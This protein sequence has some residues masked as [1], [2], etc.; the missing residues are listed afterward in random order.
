MFIF[1]NNHTKK[2]QNR[3]IERR[4]GVTEILVVEET[5]LSCKGNGFIQL[6][7]SME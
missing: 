1:L 3:R 4:K 5:S 6:E 7:G 2:E